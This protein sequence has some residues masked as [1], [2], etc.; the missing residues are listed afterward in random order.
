MQL[1]LRRWRQ[2]LGLAVALVASTA[3]AQSAPVVVEGAWARASVPGQKATG[4]FMRL[5][6]RESVQLVRVQSP[7]AEVAEVHEMKM[8]KDVMKM[9]AIP[10]LELPAG[11]TVE[12]RPGG[13]H[14]MLMDLKAPLAAGSEVP[15]T[16]VLR[17]AQ[18]VE[19]SVPLNLPVALKAPGAAAAPAPAP[20]H[21]AH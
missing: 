13:Y 8:E 12:L 16:L 21:P 15:L 10:A 14:V 18:G 6:A 9:R 4:A 2:A 19:T 17:N 5:T 1:Q 20:A 11:Q 7:A 3:W